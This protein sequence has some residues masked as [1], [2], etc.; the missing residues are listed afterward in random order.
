MEAYRLFSASQAVCGLLDEPIADLP[1][2]KA[3]AIAFLLI[4]CGNNLQ[5]YKAITAVR[6]IKL[7]NWGPA[8]CIS[9]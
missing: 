7:Q 1:E 3:L 5:E 9:F 2:F 8:T 4:L 6:G